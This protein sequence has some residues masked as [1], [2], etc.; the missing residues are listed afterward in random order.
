MRYFLGVSPNLGD[1]LISQYG[2]FL[3]HRGTPRDHPFEGCFINH[4][5]AFLRN[6]D[7]RKPRYI[8]ITSYYYRNHI[9]LWPMIGGYNDRNIKRIGTWWDHCGLVQE[10]KPSRNQV[11]NRA[12]RAYCAF[13]GRTEV[14]DEDVGKVRYGSWA[15]EAGPSSKLWISS[16]FYPVVNGRCDQRSYG[17]SYSLGRSES[18]LLIKSFP[19][20]S[21]HISPWAAKLYCLGF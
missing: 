17:H 12:A 20:I 1:V 14:T 19:T 4:P 18:E 3:S 13:D 9:S 5:A 16:K 21:H 15:H 8:R 2:A 10:S 11:T 7:C 6:P